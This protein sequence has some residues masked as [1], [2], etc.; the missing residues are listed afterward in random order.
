[1]IRRTYFSSM[2][3]SLHYCC[4]RELLS[5]VV[6]GVEGY[7]IQV[8]LHSVFDMATERRAD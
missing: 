2:P 4:G 7:A 6:T 8:E 5:F 3:F 1:M